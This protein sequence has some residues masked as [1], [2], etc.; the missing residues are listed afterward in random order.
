MAR[1]YVNTYMHDR[2]Y[3]GP[4]EGGWYYDVYEALDSIPCKSKDECERMREAAEKDAEAENKGRPPVSSVMSRG[5]L[6]VRVEDHPAEDHP[7]HRPHYE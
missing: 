5:R 3:G 2:S 4:E 7:R 6:V 1:Y